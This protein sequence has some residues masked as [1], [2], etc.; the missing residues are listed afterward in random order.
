MN[1]G[2][3]NT[4]SSGNWLSSGLAIESEIT[5][6]GQGSRLRGDFVFDRFT[7]VHGDIEGKV[8]GLAGSLIVV[9]EMGSIHGEIHCD[10][11]I[12]D[13]FVRANVEA[14]GKVTIAESG[15]LIGDVKSPKLEIR[16][17]AHFEGRAITSHAHGTKKASA[18]S[19]QAS[20]TR[21]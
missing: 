12:I 8:N 17:G 14:K 2:T 7:R 15:T 9:G 19:Q 16:F 18:E 13:G 4:P 21:A 10:E 5:L 6:I 3:S 20:S 1:L 11:L